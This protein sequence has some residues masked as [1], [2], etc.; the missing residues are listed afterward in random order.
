LGVCATTPPFK[1]TG[2]LG[3]LISPGVIL[4]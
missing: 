4:G 1:L 3:F 2:V